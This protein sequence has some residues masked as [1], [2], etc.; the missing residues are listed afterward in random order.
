MSAWILLPIALGLA[1]VLQA[2]L[3]RQIATHWGLS[4]A[5][6]LNG[7]IVAAMAILVFLLAGRYPAGFPEL[8]RPKGEL[9][10]FRAWYLLP[11]LLGIFLVLGI[12]LGMQKLGALRVFLT[13]IV[14]QIAAA[15]LWDVA[16]ERIPLTATRLIG[17]LTALAGVVLVSL[18]R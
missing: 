3:N 18:S 4:G 16:V 14:V 9:A 8:V 15:L 1:A 6:L 7:L 11:G 12:P 13:L 2:G 10:G 5:A 17:A